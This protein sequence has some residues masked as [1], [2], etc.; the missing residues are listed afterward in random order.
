MEARPI[1]NLQDFF[2]FLYCIL[3]YGPKKQY[4]LYC[5]MQLESRGGGTAGDY[6]NIFC[7]CFA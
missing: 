3:R 5:A 1:K 4:G 6:I 7:T 2:V